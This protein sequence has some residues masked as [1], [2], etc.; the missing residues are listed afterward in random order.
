[1]GKHPG[2]VSLEQLEEQI[3]ELA[4]HINAATCSWLLLIGEFD[5]REGWK[6]WG[7][8]SCAAWWSLR[9]GLS[10]GVG[11]E[12]V[13]V[14]RR[15]EGM[16]LVREAF[17]R[18]ELS[19]S[20]VRAVTRVADHADEAQLLVLALHATAAQLERLVRAYRGGGATQIARGS[21]AYGPRVLAWS[22]GYAGWLGFR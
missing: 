8:K 4:A 17:A 22:W 10:P 11:R 2:S 15:L 14:A 3:G 5:R 13:R 9:C 20:K 6:S 19:F 16:P 1:M 21:E 18:G 12:H 7:C